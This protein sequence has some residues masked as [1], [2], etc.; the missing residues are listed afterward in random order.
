MS[1]D[2]LVPLAPDNQHIVFK[3]RMFRSGRVWIKLRQGHNIV[4]KGF[5]ADTFIEEN[6]V[7]DTKL[8]RILMHLLQKRKKR[9]TTK[10]YY[11]VIKGKELIEN[12]FKA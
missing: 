7:S 10:P 5:F 3:A 9:S 6:I 4:S 1:A 8:K 11:K 2:T 12:I